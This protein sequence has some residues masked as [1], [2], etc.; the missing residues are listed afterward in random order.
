MISHIM[1]YYPNAAQCTSNMVVCLYY[2]HDESYYYILYYPSAAS[3]IWLYAQVLCLYYHPDESYYEYPSAAQVI[4][5]YAQLLCLYYHPDGTTAPVIW[6]YSICLYYH[7]TLWRRIGNQT[8]I[9]RY[10]LM[11]WMLLHSYILYNYLLAASERK[12]ERIEKD[13]RQNLISIRPYTNQK[14]SVFCRNISFR[15][16]HVWCHISSTHTF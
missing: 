14:P 9:C 1:I 12:K 15:S 5:L 13:P 7:L 8:K 10:L 2:H 16:S 4:W 3:V 6:L 11:I